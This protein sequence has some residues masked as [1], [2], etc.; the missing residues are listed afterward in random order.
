[1]GYTIN[2]KRFMT[3]FFLEKVYVRT[4]FL[5]YFAMD[6]WFT[7]TGHYIYSYKY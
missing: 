1:M 7:I 6:T 4:E 3:A 5:T 2:K